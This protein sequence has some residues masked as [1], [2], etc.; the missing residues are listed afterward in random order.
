[1]TIDQECR[2]LR[3][4]KKWEM[5]IA[6]GA[7]IVGIILG[8]VVSERRLKETPPILSQEYQ[9]VVAIDDQ[10]NDG[11]PELKATY[12][13]GSTVILYSKMNDQNITFQP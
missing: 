9:S 2:E 5:G 1:M 10:N 6:T 8:Y 3:K 11:I 13:D 12:E 7:T 4:P